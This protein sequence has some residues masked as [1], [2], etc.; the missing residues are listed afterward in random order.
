MYLSEDEIPKYWYNMRADMKNKPDP[1][2][3][4]GTR[5]PITAEEMNAVFCRELVR[6]ELD[7]DTQLIKIP[8]E[9]LEF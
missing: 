7:A 8:D 4:P 2:L 1:I 5:Q 9:L 6:Q 3:H